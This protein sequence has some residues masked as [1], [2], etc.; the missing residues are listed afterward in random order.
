MQIRIVN[1]SD[2]P[3][4]LVLSAEYDRYVKESVSDLSEWYGGNEAAPAFDFYMR[5]K[6][7]QREAFM[8]VDRADNCLGIIALSKKNNRI[9]FF[10]VSHGTDFPVV[11]NALFCSA[12]ELL[13]AS[14]PIYINEIISASDW[15][16]LH[17]ELYSKLGFAFY[18]DIIEN[19][20]P[21]KTLAKMP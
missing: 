5:S 11:A 9:T 6:V 2:I 19:G 13:D 12:F 17:H 18:S 21:V 15:M 10:G 20:V 14:K 4:W 3:R 16:R 7:L 8:A 1:D